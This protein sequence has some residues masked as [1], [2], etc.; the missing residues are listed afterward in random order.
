MIVKNE[1]GAHKDRHAN[2]GFGHIGFDALHYIVHHPQ[3]SNVPKIL[4]TPYVGED[5]ASKKP[6]YKWEIAMLRNGEFDPDL[7]NKIQND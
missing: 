5:K 1:R 2:I 3:L 6:P 4:E 7:L